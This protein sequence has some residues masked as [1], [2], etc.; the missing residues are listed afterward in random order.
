MKMYFVGEYFKGTLAMFQ[1]QYPEADERTIY[2]IA[3]ENDL[4]VVTEWLHWDIK[5]S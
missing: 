3:F 5:N 1:V 4:E 2:E